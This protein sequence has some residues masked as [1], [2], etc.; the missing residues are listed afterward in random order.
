[1]ETENKE[2]A[3][4][5]YKVIDGTDDWPIIDII[6]GTSEQDCIDQAEQKYGSNND[7]HWTNPY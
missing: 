4:K 3:L 6:T 1:M 5:I 2:Y 7:Y